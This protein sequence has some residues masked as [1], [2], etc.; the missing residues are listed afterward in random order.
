MCPSTASLLG[1]RLLLKNP[2]LTQPCNLNIWL[3]V[4][5]SESLTFQKAFLAHCHCFTAC[6]LS[7]STETTE[8]TVTPGKLQVKTSLINGSHSVTWCR[9]GQFTSLLPSE[10]AWIQ[11]LQSF[12]CVV[13]DTLSTEKRRVF[14]S[15]V[16]PAHNILCLIFITKETVKWKAVISIESSLWVVSHCSKQ[17]AQVQWHTRCP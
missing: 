16:L 9:T 4:N 5:S 6:V 13:S 3:H 7:S 17:T 2:W 8:T 14:I 12:K 1:W 15:K 10:S 11:N